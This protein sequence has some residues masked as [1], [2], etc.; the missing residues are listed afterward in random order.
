MCVDASPARWEIRN[1]GQRSKFAENKSLTAQR[2]ER[3]LRQNIGSASDS[4]VDCACGSGS[5]Q[6]EEWKH[7]VCKCAC[8]YVCE[9][10]SKCVWAG[11]WAA[12][13]PHQH[14]HT[15]TRTAEQYAKAK[16]EA[17]FV[18]VV[19]GIVYFFGNCHCCVGV[20]SDSDSVTTTATTATKQRQTRSTYSIKFL[21]WYLR[22]RIKFVGVVAV[23]GDIAYLLLLLLL[24]L[25]HIVVAVSVFVLAFVYVCDV[26]SVSRFSIWMSG[27]TYK[28]DCWLYTDILCLS[29]VHM[30]VCIY[31]VYILS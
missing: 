12:A 8:V 15:H 5:D 10:S 30:Y 26:V 1:G 9:L 23:V 17:E 21:L 13:V 14:T 20:D 3:R 24:L 6:T 31:L 27:H 11:I 18:V 19:F 16:A 28:Y 7:S 29:Y 22:T 2:Y 25:S 4:D